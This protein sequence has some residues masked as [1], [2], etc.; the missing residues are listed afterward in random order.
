MAACRLLIVTPQTDLRHS[1]AFTLE[2]HG[3]QAEA[4]EGLPP[5]NWT[6][7]PAFSCTI[8]D[9]KALT[10][11]PYETIAFC[12]KAA[13]VVLLTDSPVGWISEWTRAVIELPVVGDALV[14]AVRA[15]MHTEAGTPPAC[16]RAGPAQACM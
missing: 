1:L 9:Q 6:G 10:G 14:D 15:S 16:S 2:A 5:R 13:P 7:A 12:I 4:L 3:Y 11:E 8:L